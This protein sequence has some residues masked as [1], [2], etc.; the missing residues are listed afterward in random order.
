M[1]GDGNIPCGSDACYNPD[2]GE[3]CC[4][5]GYY[6]DAGYTCSSTVG[7]CSYGSGLSGGSST[8]SDYGYLTA[9]SSY[10]FGLATSTSAFGF[11]T[12]ASTPTTTGSGSSAT[13][14]NQFSSDSSDGRV[15]AVGRGLLVAAGA[16]VL[17]L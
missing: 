11:S 14:V 2:I 17:V 12:A 13:G 8:T 4:A 9:T 7:K 15:L 16:A 1:Y 10:D 5:G 3:S 6:C